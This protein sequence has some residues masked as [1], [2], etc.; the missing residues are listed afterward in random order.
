MMKNFSLF[1]IVVLSWVLTSCEKQKAV[2]R[3]TNAFIGQY[4][5]VYTKVY[6]Y[7]YMTFEESEHR[8]G[9]D[10]DKKSTISLFRDGDLQ[11]TYKL[12]RDKTNDALYYEQYKKK[13]FLTIS[14]DTVVLTTFPY[15]NSPNYFLRK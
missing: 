6:D 9:I 5:W 15:Y 14:A 8:F 10:I 7:D 11:G 2:N 13:Q 4:E 1:G 12:T 3:K